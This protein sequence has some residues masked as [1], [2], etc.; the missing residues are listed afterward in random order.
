MR[1]YLYLLCFLLLAIG[2]QVHAQAPAGASAAAW[3]EL[4]DNELRLHTGSQSQAVTKNVVLPNGTRLDYRTHTAVLADGRSVLLHEGD[5]VSLNGTIN[6]AQQSAEQSAPTPAAAVAAPAAAAPATPAAAA[7]LTPAAVAP[8]TVAPAVVPAVT[9]RPTATAFTYQPAAPINGRLKGVVELGASGFNSFIVRIDGQKRWALERAEYGNSL[10]MENIATPDDVRRGLKAYIGQ[11]LDYGVG[12]R[13]IHFVVSSGAALADVTKRIVPALKELG[14]VV[15]MVTTEQEG[16]YGLRAALPAGFSGRAFVLDVGS[17]NTKLAW[18]DHGQPR[19]AD[20][21]G[22][23]YY[24]QQIDAAT[25]A[26]SVRAAA[27][28]VPASQRATCFVLGGVPY[29]LAKTSRQ[30]QERYTQL[31]PPAEYT[32]SGGGA[33]LAAGLNIYSAVAE[34][35]GCQ[36]FVF[37]WAANFTIGY[38]LTLP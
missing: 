10:V 28:Q 29:E 4:R 24:Q 37:D 33:K 17:G 3:F 38:L 21:Y 36:Q 22:A 34:T 20:T 31:L 27:R 12:G 7:T 8:P 19:T 11:M 26:G 35:T 5:R 18:L 6:A 16:I 23:K 25:V 14:Y 32:R 30:G 1:L 9:A 15:H 2:G 13:D